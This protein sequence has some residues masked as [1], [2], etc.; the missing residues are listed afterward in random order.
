MSGD[1]DAA[2]PLA[3]ILGCLVYLL[4]IGA[5]AATVAQNKGIQLQYFSYAW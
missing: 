5:S 3:A 2:V 1:S 4:G